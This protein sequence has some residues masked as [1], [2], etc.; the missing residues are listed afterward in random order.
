MIDENTYAIQEFLVL[1]LHEKPQRIQ[2]VCDIYA[3]GA[4]LFKLILG[5]APT[6]QISHYIAENKMHIIDKQ[7]N[8][9][10]IP[11]FFK[12]FVLSN[13]IC[14]IIVRML[15]RDQQHRFQTLQEVRD[16]LSKLQENIL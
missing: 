2:K 5:R 9:Y 15:H 7:S 8:V 10:E 12:D 11:Y 13:D 3:L 16:E 6:Q 4:I 14:Q 1:K